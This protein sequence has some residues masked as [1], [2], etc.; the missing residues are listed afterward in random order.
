MKGFADTNP[1]VASRRVGLAI[2]IAAVVTI[3][4]PP[5]HAAEVHATG[6]MRPFGSTVGPGGDLYVADAAAG[7]IVRVD[8]RTGETSIY[9]GG[10]PISPV[11]GVFGIGGVMDVT[12]LDGVAY[13]LVTLVSWD[14]GGSDVVGIYQLVDD[15][16]WSVVADI[17]TFAFDNLPA[18][19]DVPTGIQYAIQAFRGGFLVTDGNH[20]RVLRVTPGGAISTVA[21]FGN[22][23]PTGLAVRGNDVYLALAGPAPHLPEAGRI[24]RLDAKTWQATEIASGAPLL[25]DVELGRGNSLLGL[26]QGEGIDGAPAGA[27]AMPNSGTLVALDGAGG[28]T[29]IDGPIDLPTSMAVI[30]STAYVVSLDGNVYRVPDVSNPPFGK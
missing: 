6:L 9:A 19:W 13:A 1:G 24:L 12:F 17:G 27:P 26:S 2:L 5:S 4:S 10:L 20:N 23:V 7:A 8:A 29:F 30:R 18:L 21:Q 14:I 22:E 16:S 15:G 28:F 11:I 25:V 3:V